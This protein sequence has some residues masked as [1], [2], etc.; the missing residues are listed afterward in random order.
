M[1]SWHRIDG[2]SMALCAWLA[3]G[4]I[5]EEVSEHLHEGRKHEGRRAAWRFLAWSSILGIFWWASESN[6]VVATLISPNCS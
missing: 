6:L 4:F 1:T 5:F 3:V 2:M